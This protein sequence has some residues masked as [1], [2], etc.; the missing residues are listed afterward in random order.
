MTRILGIDPGA[1]TGW[2]TY[3]SERRCVNDS[4]W[5]ETTLVSWQG[6]ITECDV[7]VIEKP[8]VFPGS[9]PNMGDAC[10]NSGILWHKLLT[11]FG[12]APLWLTMNEIRSR[13][14][15]ATHGEINARNNATVTAALRIVHGDDSDKRPKIKKGKVIE[16][17][18]PIYVRNNH[19][20]DALAAAWACAQD[21]SF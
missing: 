18:G 19:E 15:R 11:L 4:G 1:K 2:C 7:I 9:P 21:L 10:I 16:E 8:R 3:D 14:S 5:F 12:R 20:R 17:G 6:E 13:L